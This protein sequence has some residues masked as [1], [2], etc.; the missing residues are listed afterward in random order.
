M[1]C[2]H[3]QQAKHTRRLGGLL[4]DL[5]SSLRGESHQ[6]RGDALLIPR[7]LVF[8][9][10]ESAGFLQRDHGSP[11]PSLVLLQQHPSHQ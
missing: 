1:A 7:P 4:K 8:A 2:P 3:A 5:L 9:G 10:W 6:C 11:G